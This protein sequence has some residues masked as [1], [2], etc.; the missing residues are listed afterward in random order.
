MVE[1]S[2]R[3]SR[4]VA[5]LSAGAAKDS[6]TPN[7]VRH[8]TLEQ[9]GVKAPKQGKC[10]AVLAAAQAGKLPP[11]LDFSAASHARYWGAAAGL[12]S[13]AKAGDIEGLKAV[14]IK[15]YSSSPKAMAKYRDLAVIALEAR[16]AAAGA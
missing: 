5:T 1:E 7:R 14:V 4:K 6:V 13:L 2:A 16:G 3:D 12:V 8:L 10:A 11:P 15:P 9:L